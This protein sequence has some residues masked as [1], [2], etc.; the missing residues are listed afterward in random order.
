MSLVHT[1]PQELKD[2]V[3]NKK[4]IAF[5]GAGASINCGLPSWYH[6]VQNLLITQ[7]SYIDNAKLFNQSMEANILS[8]LEVLDK[9][10]EHKKIV[11]ESFEQQLKDTSI[12]SDLHVALGNLTTKFITTNFDSLIEFNLNIKDVITSDSTFNLSKLDTNDSYVLKPHGDISQID[13]CII[14]SKQYEELYNEEKFS[15][16]QLKKLLTEYTF[17]FIGFSFDDPYVAD[18]FNYV[19]N[20]CE[21][22]GPKH[23]LIADQEKEI[24]NIKTVCI[25]SYENLVPFITSLSVDNKKDEVGLEISSDVISQSD[26]DGSDIPPDVLNWVGREKELQRLNSHTFKVIFITGIGGE[27]KSALAS[28][29]L[30]SLQGKENEIIDWR[31]FKEEEHKFQ[32]K[33][34]AMIRLLS[35]EIS[36]TKLAGL[37]DDELVTFFFKTLGQRESVFVL[38]NIDSYI[39]LET[40]EPTN[41]IGKLFNTALCIEHKAKFIFT[42]RPFIR[43]AS[44]DFF[45]LNLSGFTEQNTIDYFN[46][47]ENCI[48]KVKLT[49]YAI[50]AH[51][52]TN[53][54]ALWLSIISAQSKR[55]EKS[56]LKFLE[57]IESGITIDVNDSSILSEK[58]LGSIWGSLHEREQLLLRTLA[59]SVKA[60]TTEDYSEILRTELNY[61]NFSRALKALRSLNLIVNKRNTDYIELH[62]LVKEYIRKNYQTSDRS[63][64]I[65]LFIQY[66]DKFVFVLKEKLSYKLSFDEFSNFTNKA[67]LSINKGDFQEAITTLWEVHSAMSAAGYIEEFL[68]VAKLLFNAVTWSKK[69]IAKYTNFETLWDSVS[70]SSVEFG[71]NDF[72]NDLIQKYENLIENK[73]EEYIRLCHVKSYVHWF[74]REYKEAVNICEE[75][76]YLLKRADQPDKFGIEHHQALAY[77]DSEISENIEKALEF[78]LK[79]NDLDLLLDNGKIEQSG[80][81]PMYGNIGKCLALQGKHENSL[82]TF[83][84]SFYYIFKDDS[85]NRLINLGYAALWISEALLKTNKIES[86]FYFYKFALISWEASSPVLVNRNKTSFTE[87]QSSSTYKSI[88]SQENWRIEKY[89]LDWVSAVLKVSF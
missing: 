4:M 42:C 43:H 76:T 41:G 36:I 21:G 15:T 60:E 22:Y 83:Y 48:S 61:K 56:L 40:F 8:P 31:D 54:H 81:G 52:L 58:V 75:A 6:L 47:G 45:Q 11:Y 10:Y 26:I 17:L 27:G 34:L 88:T 12:K 7:E 16:F 2:A 5:L 85:S 20:L 68:R 14:F 37:N 32:H 70:R 80:D 62:P 71:E 28:H 67:E 89:C 53:G 9:I 86:A 23:F 50:K 64:Y 49:E 39:D 82:V 55:G 51:K 74:R 38:D 3:Q 46:T 57:N 78:F 65:S 24:K 72:T 13:R 73:E 66:Y 84:K 63:K 1:I 19:S 33:M 79:N 87:H 35:P 29:Y 25:D 30:N 44:I 59:E 18:L 77:R 69:N